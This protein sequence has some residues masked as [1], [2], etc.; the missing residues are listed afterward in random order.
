MKMPKKR[1][2]PN[3]DF[4]QSAAVLSVVLGRPRS[5]RMIRFTMS[6]P[7]C[8]SPVYFPVLE[9]RLRAQGLLKVLDQILGRLQAHR[10]ADEAIANAEPRTF[11]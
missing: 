1:K 10:Q 5:K 4:A 8:T 9:H 7:F 11:L 6:P 3:R 2:A